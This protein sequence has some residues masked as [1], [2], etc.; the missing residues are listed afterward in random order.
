M[1]FRSERY[2]EIRKN[3]WIFRSKKFDRIPLFHHPLFREP[4]PAD[5]DFVTQAVISQKFSFGKVG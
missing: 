4:I 2:S 1:L 5:A 3:R